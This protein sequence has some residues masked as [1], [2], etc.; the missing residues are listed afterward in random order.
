[1]KKEDILLRILFR[2]NDRARFMKFETKLRK[3]VMT[4]KLWSKGKWL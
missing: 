2:K 1:M 4:G 3:S